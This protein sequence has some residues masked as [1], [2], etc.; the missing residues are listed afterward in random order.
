MAHR[1]PLI[2]VSHSPLWAVEFEAECHLIASSLSGNQFWIEHVGSTAVSGL[3]AKPIID[4]VLGAESLHQI[5]KWVPIL[6]DIGYEYLPQNEEVMPNRRF[7]AKPHIR[8][9]RFHLHGT[10]FGGSFWNEHLAFRDA[11]RRN[12]VLAEEYS[13][14]KFQLADKFVDDRE[15]YTNAKNPFISEVLRHALG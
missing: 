1:A 9:R 5:E 10:V 13:K 12:P 7:F 14:L 11:L 2:V 8:P 6:E 15:G 4:V 3:S